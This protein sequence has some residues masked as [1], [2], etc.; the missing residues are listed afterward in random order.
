MNCWFLIDL[1]SIENLPLSKDGDF[2]W[3]RAADLHKT[4]GISTCQSIRIWRQDAASSFVESRLKLRCLLYFSHWCLLSSEFVVPANAKSQKL[5][6]KM[7]FMR[8]LPNAAPKEQ[9]TGWLDKGLSVLDL[10]NAFEIRWWAVCQF[11]QKKSFIFPCWI[12]RIMI[13]SELLS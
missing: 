11:A 9:L 8:D 12:Q 3:L 7:L 6:M 1:K 4:I 13:S 5:R 2:Q 10:K